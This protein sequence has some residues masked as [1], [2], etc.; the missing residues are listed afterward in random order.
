MKRVSI[1]QRAARASRSAEGSP[2]VQIQRLSRP[3]A[4][5]SGWT[6]GSSGP[7]GP[8]RGTAFCAPPS[9]AAAWPPPAS[10]SPAGTA[11][12]WRAAP[13]GLSSSCSCAP[14][15]ERGAAPPPRGTGPEERVWDQLRYDLK[16]HWTPSAGRSEQTRDFEGP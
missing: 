15:S 13:C 3:A 1:V 8:W 9:V 10:P 4:P 11:C 6:S 2:Q 12:V 5:P 7:P 14:C 16:T